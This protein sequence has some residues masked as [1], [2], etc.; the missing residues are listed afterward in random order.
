MAKGRRVGEVLAR[1]LEQVRKARGLT[2]RDVTERLA[3]LGVSMHQTAIAKIE[4]GDRKVTI[5]DALLLAFA[6]DVAP[7]NLFLPLADNIP[8]ALGNV[9]VQSGEMRAWARGFAPLP[10]QDSRTYLT[11][12]PDGEWAPL[13][14]EARRAASAEDFRSFADA[15]GGTITYHPD[16]EPTE[17]KKGRPRGP[18]S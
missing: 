17:P 6:L 10:G 4:N 13:E 5:E 16:E 3:D 18:R 7:V 15:T 14:K 12:V 2:Q 11:Q 9:T 1:R 8:M